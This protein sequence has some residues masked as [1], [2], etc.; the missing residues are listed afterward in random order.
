MGKGQMFDFRCKQL[1]MKKKI[2]GVILKNKNI[3]QFQAVETSE[4]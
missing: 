4:S 2:T 3:I 1:F